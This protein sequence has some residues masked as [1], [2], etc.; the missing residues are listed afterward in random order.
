MWMGRRI[1]N[2]CLNVY[3]KNDNS[4]YNYKYD[5]KKLRKQINIILGYRISIIR[6]ADIK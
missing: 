2:K 4:K 5:E 3:C 6:M 1:G